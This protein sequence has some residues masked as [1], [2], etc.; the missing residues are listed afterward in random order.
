LRPA[1]LLLISLISL[2]YILGAFPEPSGGAEVDEYGDWGKIRAVSFVIPCVDEYGMPT[3]NPDG[4]FYPNDMFKIRYLVQVEGGVNFD[5][6]DISYNEGIFEALDMSGWGGLSGSGIFRVRLGAS[7]GTY[8]FSI[9][10]W[11]NKTVRSSRIGTVTYGGA[12]VDA[13]YKAWCLLIISVNNV[14]VGATS[15]PPGSYWIQAWDEVRIEAFPNENHTIDSWI[16]DDVVLPGSPSITVQMDKPHNVTA[17]FK[18]VNQTSQN[19]G[20]QAPSEALNM[21]GGG[22]ALLSAG[23]QSQ[24]YAAVAG[25]LPSA[26]G[27]SSSGVMP[28]LAV[29]GFMWQTWFDFFRG[30]VCQAKGVVYSSDGRSVEGATVTVEFLK[31]NVVTGAIWIVQKAAVLGEDGA[32]AVEDTCFPL[33]EAFLDVV[34]WA[35]GLGYLPSWRLKMHLNKEAVD[36]ERGRLAIFGVKVD[37][38]GRFSDV[39]VSLD[40]SG[41]PS[42]CVISF[43]PASGGVSLFRGF[44]SMAVISASEDAP[45]GSRTIKVAAS[46]GPVR[47]EGGLTVTVREFKVKEARS[48]VQ[49]VAN[50]LHADALG[51]VLT[52]D[53]ETPDAVYLNASQLPYSAG[54]KVDSVHAFEWEAE[55]SSIINGKRYT[56]DYTNVTIIYVA[57]T[58]AVVTVVE[59]D[60]HFTFLLAYSILNSTS[61]MTDSAGRSSYEKP[62]G[63]IVRYDGNGPSLNL[64]QRA[65]IEGFSWETWL[66]RGWNMTAEEGKLKEVKIG[67]G[68]YVFH[69]VGVDESAQE[70]ILFADGSVYTYNSLPISFNWAPGS[71][72][73]YQWIERV[74]STDEAWFIF[75]DING[76][77]KPYGVINASISG[78]VVVGVYAKYKR[79]LTFLPPLER[80]VRVDLNWTRA[81]LYYANGSLAKAY[82]IYGNKPVPPLLFAGGQ[83]YALFI[84]KPDYEVMQRAKSLNY[85]MFYLDLNYYTLRFTAQPKLAAKVSYTLFY[86]VFEQPIQIKAVKN[87]KGEWVVDDGVRFNVTFYPGDVPAEKDIY[88]AWFGNQTADAVAVSIALSDVYN[89]VPQ[90]IAGQGEASALLNKTSPQFFKVEALV[91]GYGKALRVV[92]ENV[93]VKFMEDPYIL[94]INMAGGGV[95]ASVLE[96]WNIGAVLGIT[97][98]PE[99]GGAVRVTVRDEGGRVLFKQEFMGFA[100]T[101]RGVFGFSGTLTPTVRKYPGGGSTVTITV[102]NDWGAVTAVSVAVKPYI[103]PPF[104]A[105]L[106]VIA[107]GIAAI[108][109]AAVIMALVLRFWRREA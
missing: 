39:P 87:V 73:V 100:E 60:P 56:F 32:F 77:S 80:S 94:Y 97:I 72:H 34:A 24:L 98:A 4:T 50:G 29:K 8:A 105:L 16:I 89:P 67:F 17:I 5:R 82:E 85:S 33:F 57:Y 76:A 2:A 6:V 96:E 61:D 51:R 40:A 104:I 78:G 35:E 71:T 1:S 30:T 55:V 49:F 3:V 26:A 41:L 14:S 31:K 21:P 88:S 45:L 81:R 52:L 22:A 54:W 64:Q 18:Y 43:D 101:Q 20:G 58:N 59:Y 36:V 7:P 47:A 84:Y 13:Y 109:V 99:V 53:G 86:E 37:V 42:G 10:A 70:P 44:V 9:S 74:Y 108:I 15:P 68:N 75:Q 63:F 66:I 48:A 103:E 62:I 83:R 79:P 93:Y 91:W 19:S 38:E 25:Q 92:R 23:A 65:L 106:D 95:N 107:W 11:A 102:E 28:F 46:S 90:W 27:S 69:A 12:I